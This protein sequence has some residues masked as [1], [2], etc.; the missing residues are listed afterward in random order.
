MADI[1]SS[2]E[3]NRGSAAA[4]DVL[5]GLLELLLEYYPDVETWYA[6]S[7]CVGDDPESIDS[8]HRELLVS[9][10]AS[11]DRTQ[12]LAEIALEAQEPWA[13]LSPP[14]I[15]KAAMS[16]YDHLKQI[17]DY[18]RYVAEMMKRAMYTSDEDADEMMDFNILP[19]LQD[20]RKFQRGMR[21]LRPPQFLLKGRTKEV[22]PRQ[23]ISGSKPAADT[24]REE[25]APT[26]ERD[27]QQIVRAGN[28]QLD[29]DD[30]PSFLAVAH[31]VPMTCL[32]QLATVLRSE[33]LS[34]LISASRD[35]ETATGKCPWREQLRI[36]WLKAFDT[37]RQIA[38]V[39]I[40][41][42]D[43]PLDSP[44]TGLVRETGT[45][46]LDFA[47]EYREFRKVVLHEEQSRPDIS[48]RLQ[49]DGFGD[50]PFPRSPDEWANCF[51]RP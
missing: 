33:S 20:V 45:C 3:H 31:W 13:E 26:S 16:V 15:Q 42:I 18:R 19:A 46:L 51:I 37:L 38:A 21:L 49:Q 22:K 5:V 25:T 27:G 7:S 2:P 30:C 9:W 23:S 50:D 1:K 41:D 32:N 36:L 6:D 10:R 29:I 28:H 35:P 44:T 12:M 43:D 48:E 40:F 47:A 11:Y 34:M 17:R 39:A 24:P 14:T 8:V 4:H